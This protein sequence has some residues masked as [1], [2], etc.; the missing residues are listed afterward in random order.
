MFAAGRF[1]CFIFVMVIARKAS[2]Y[3]KKPKVSLLIMGKVFHVYMNKQPF[4]K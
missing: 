3:N 4:V 1:T 2:V